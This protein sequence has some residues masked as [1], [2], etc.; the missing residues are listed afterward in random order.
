M[1]TITDAETPSL[2]EDEIRLG[3]LGDEAERDA[4]LTSLYDQYSEQLVGYLERK[5]PGLPPDLAANAMVDTFRALN[6]EVV[7]ATFD[8]DRP[9][10]SFLFAVVWNKGVDEL[11]RFTC[12]A[13][14]NSDFYDVVG[15][16]LQGTEMGREWAQD[17]Q[18]GVADELA[19][20]FRDFL[21]SLPPV[22]RQIAQVI[23]DNFPNRI[24]EEQICEEVFRRTKKRMTVVQVKS[25]KREIRRKFKEILN[26]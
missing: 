9:L 5:L 20:E 18:V 14:G 26:K 7:A 22:Q 3:L 13:L 12:R 17:V 4:A 24:P 15:E 8:Y 16:S 11:R 2:N 23:A 25:A 1:S 6:D 10:T 21:F 19:Q